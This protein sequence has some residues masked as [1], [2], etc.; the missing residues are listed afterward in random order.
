MIFG[1]QVTLDDEDLSV[2]NGTGINDS[3]GISG[4][5]SKP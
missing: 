5:H 4:R 1:R 3:N 2:D